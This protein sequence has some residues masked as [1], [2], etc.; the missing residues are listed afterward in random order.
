MLSKSWKVDY[1][2]VKVYLHI[3]SNVFFR[4]LCYNQENPWIKHWS[5]HSLLQKFIKP[6]YVQNVFFGMPLSKQKSDCNL[7]L[8][9][10]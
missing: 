9:E 2:I 10:F 4:K 3:L 5:Y 1:S 8:F 6:C 7:R